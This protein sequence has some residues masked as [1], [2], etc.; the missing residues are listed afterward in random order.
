MNSPLDDILTRLADE[1]GP[2]GARAALTA[3]LAELTHSQRAYVGR[4]WRGC[5]A[6]PRQLP[7]TTPGWLSF[8]FCGARAMGKTRALAEYVNA[9]ASAHRIDIGLAGQNETAAI[10]VMILGKSGLVEV[11]APWNKAHFETSSGVV[12]WANGSRAYLRSPEAPGNIRGLNI[13][14][15]WLSE[16]QSW[17]TATRKEAIDNFEFATREPGCQTVWDAT[18]SLSSI[19]KD[20]EDRAE[21]DPERHVLVR[22]SMHENSR[23]LDPSFIASLERQYGGTRRGRAEILGEKI[24]ASE[25]ALVMQ[26]WI[27]AA[28]RHLPNQFVRKVLG[29]DPALSNR[30]GSDRTGIVLTGSGVDGQL[31]VIADF[32]GKYSATQWGE[33]LLDIYSKHQVD[34]CVVEANAGHELVAQNI[35]LLAPSRGLELVSIGPSERPSR[36]PGA[37]L[38]KEVKAVGKKAVRAGP[39]SAAYERG[40][41]SHVIGADLTDLEVELTTWEPPPDDRRG[42]ESPDRIDALV[43]S[44]SDQLDLTGTAVAPAMRP[45]DAEMLRQMQAQLSGKVNAFDPSRKAHEAAKR[46]KYAQYL[47][48]T[49]KY[50]RMP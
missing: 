12:H 44:A 5:F 11:S 37:I 18:P 30:P 22:G 17:P 2:A 19:V 41:V 33:L 20:W 35:R 10:D 49:G 9:Q 7:P 47:S 38:I 25:L 32:S 4:A 8:G 48:R 34:Y 24:V 31:Y 6:R 42:G 29:I 23:N 40:R 16:L 50:E 3:A 27:D 13:K 36:R 39:L 26:L 15:A 21:A 1:L 14:L 43:H 28:R 45:G 46:A